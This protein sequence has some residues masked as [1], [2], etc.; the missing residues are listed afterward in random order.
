MPA[1]LV[2]SAGVT[3]ERPND[4]ILIELSLHVAEMRALARQVLAGSAKAADQAAALRRIAA[5]RGVKDP[6]GG[7]CEDA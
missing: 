3:R 6:T 1:D 5:G 2:S 7:G 4:R